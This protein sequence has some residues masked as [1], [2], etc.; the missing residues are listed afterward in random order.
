MLTMVLVLVAC[1]ALALL[2]LAIYGLLL[3]RAAFGLVAEARG[4]LRGRLLPALEH[5]EQAVGQFSSQLESTGRLLRQGEHFLLLLAPLLV[6]L[7]AA[8][9]PLVRAAGLL[10]RGAALLRRA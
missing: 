10:Q 2:G 5:T 7:G 8:R 4:A 1:C 6:A 3:V 9:L